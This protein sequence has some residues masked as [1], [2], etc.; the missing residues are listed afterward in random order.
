MAVALLLLF[1]L[2][3]TVVSSSL[4][5]FLTAG[6]QCR[7]SGHDS[8]LRLACARSRG[9]SLRSVDQSQG[10]RKR[11][12]TVEQVPQRSLSGPAE[13]C[14]ARGRGFSQAPG[15]SALLCVGYVSKTMT[16]THTTTTPTKEKLYPNTTPQRWQ[17]QHE[18]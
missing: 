9:G 15:T 7:K 18:P 12:G 17:G 2:M 16:R 1:L 8:A 4:L 14:W 5:F 10:L 11:Q 6:R 3:V 13:L